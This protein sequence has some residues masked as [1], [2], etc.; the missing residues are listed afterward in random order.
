M[1]KD[2][3]LSAP[4]KECAGCFLRSQCTG[5]IACARQFT[6]RRKSY[7][8]SHCN[9]FTPIIP[10]PAFPDRGRESEGGEYDWGDPA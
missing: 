7:R 1:K 2:V 6:C 5:C 3:W 10:C 9:L 4:L 8:A